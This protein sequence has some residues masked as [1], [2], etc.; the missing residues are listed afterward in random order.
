MGRGRKPEPAQAKVL[1]GNFRSD[2]HSHGPQVSIE[3]PKCP[4]WLPKSAKKVWKEIAPE[5]ERA[6]LITLLDKTTLAAYCDS[7]GKFEEVTRR[8]VSLEQML[9][10]T[11][12]DYMVQSALFTI[13]NK[14]WDQVMKA[15]QEF[16]L[17]P[18][19][20][21]K[22]KDTG[23]QRLPFGGGEWDDV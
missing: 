23:Q 9:D 11:P 15:A 1:K 20:R 6:G 16:G 17:S 4:T 22:V 12:Q 18:A 19:G 10:K 14:L 7:A 13:R 3:A 2:R 5:L 8:L 21:T